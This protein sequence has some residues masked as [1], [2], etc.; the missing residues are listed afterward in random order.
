MWQ[1]LIVGLIVLAAALYALRR[2][3]PGALR[4]RLGLSAGSGCG[5]CK[6]CGGT[7]CAPQTGARPAATE[8]RWQ[9]PAR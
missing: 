5:D 4:Q 2:W 8:L 7:R 6:A 9:P 1:E 3:L